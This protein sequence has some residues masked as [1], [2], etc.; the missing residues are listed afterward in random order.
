MAFTNS[1]STVIWNSIKALKKNGLL[2]TWCQEVENKIDGTTAAAG[3]KLTTVKL[4]STTLTL[5]TADGSN[6]Q[7]LTT[8]GAGT[9]SWGASAGTFAG[10]A[11]TS[12][13]AMANGEYIRPQGT[14]AAQVVALQAYDIDNTTFRNVISGTNDAATAAVVVGDA[15]ASLA[16][17]STALTVSTA[18]AVSGVTTIAASGDITLATTK[19][20]KSSVT[21]TQTVG[22]S[23]YDVDGTSYRNVISATN[24]NT[25][26]VVVGSTYNSLAVASTGLNVSTA[27]AVSGVASINFASGAT[28][29]LDQ[30][31]VSAAELK[32]LFNTPKTLVAAP[33][34]HAV[35][36]LVSCVIFYKSSGS[37]YGTVGN[38]LTIKYTNG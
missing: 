38:N 15:A 2:H 31:A 16:I 34:T 24:G 29:Y 32:D 11:I 27:G 26:A 9:V 17:A 7:Q 19:V 33:G 5:P 23:V 13:I 21:D 14:T 12:D 6:G 30:V 20:V 4:G 18:G 36:D 10:G 3:I 28:M 22:M 8:D 35:V 1:I 37:G 25:P